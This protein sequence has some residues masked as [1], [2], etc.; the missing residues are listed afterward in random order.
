MRTCQY[1]ERPANKRITTRDDYG[2]VHDIYVCD[3]HEKPPK[4]SSRKDY[5][6]GKY[7]K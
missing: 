7:D 6:E 2:R 5:M 3:T 1:C 4:E